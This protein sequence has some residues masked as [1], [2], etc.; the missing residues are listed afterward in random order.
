MDSVHIP[1]GPATPMRKTLPLLLLLVLPAA[2][3][4]QAPYLVKDINAT[5]AA[6]PASSNPY[7]FVRYGS[8]IVFSATGSQATGRELWSTDGTPG[9]TSLVA[10][11]NPG[12]SA[13]NPSH[14]AVVNGTLIF[15]ARDQRGDELWMSDGT[16][17]GTSLLADINPGAPSS[18]PRERIVYRGRMLFRASESVYGE[19]LWVT[20]G[21]PAGTRLLRDLV[22]GAGHSSPGSFVLFNDLVYFHATGGL[23]K[24]DGTEAGTVLVKPL[25]SANGLTLAG[26]R[27]FFTG[28]DAQ[29]GGEP[30]VSDGTEAGTRMIADIAP[31]SASSAGNGFLHGMTAFGDRVMFPANDSQHGTEMWISDGTAAGTRMLRD[32]APG[33]LHSA[34]LSSVAVL[35]GTA[36]FVAKPLIGRTELWKTDGTE[37]GTLLVRD[38]VPGILGGS[39]SSTPNLVAAGGKVFFGATNG[40]PAV[41]WVSDGTAQGTRP[42]KTMDPSLKVAELP[43]IFTSIDGVVYFSGAN[44]V[45]GYE[46]WKSDGTDAGTSMIANLA[47]DLAPSSE[48]DRLTAAADW[49]YFSAWNGLGDPSSEILT[50][51]LWRSD[52]TPEG[53]LEL[54]TSA[55]TWSAIGRS[56]FFLRSGSLW[57]TDGT[58]EGTG[59]ANEFVKRFP[60]TPALPFAVGDT[61]FAYAANQLWATTLTPGA[62][63]VP[64]GAGG[65]GFTDVAG[66]VLYFSLLSSPSRSTITSTDG[67]TAGT[68]IVS[69]DVMSSSADRAVMGG[70]LYFVTLTNGTKLWK[71]DGTADG[72][73][74]VKELPQGLGNMVAAGKNLFFTAG[75]QLWV[76]DGTEPGTRALAVSP[77][78][79]LAAVGNR[80]VFVDTTA[81][82]GAELWVS[83]GT[84]EGTG[85]VLDIRPGTFGSS[86][87]E[88]TSVAGLV[89]FV[90]LNDVYGS[91]LWVTDGTAAGTRLAADVEPGPG[92]SFPRQLVRA[93]ERL[94][95]VATTTATGRELWTLPLET[96]RLT[97]KDTRVAEGSG[98]TATARF[99]VTLTSAATQNVTVGYETSDGAAAAGSDYDATSGTLTFAAGETSKSITVPV[100]G[101][102]ASENDEAFFV[103][104]RNP[105][106]ATLERTSAFAVIEDDDRTA[107][108]SL[109]LDFSSFQS[110]TVKANASNSGPNTATNIKGALTATPPNP[111]VTFCNSCV[112]GQLVPG[113]MGN[114]VQSVSTT[115]PQRYFSMT[116]TARERDPNPSSNSVGWTANG[117][118]AMD[119][120]SLAPGSQANVWLYLSTPVTS[121]SLESS[122]P[123]VVSVPASVTIPADRKPV[124]FVARGLSA[125][126]ATIRAFTAAGTQSTLVID[127][128][129]PGTK[130]RWPG[131]I[132]VSA[133]N[134]FR[135]DQPAGITLDATA[136]APFNG[137]SATGLVTIAVD[138]R[139]V[140]RVTLTGSPRTWQVPSFYMPGVGA[141]SLTVDYAGDAN[142]LPVM[143]TSSILVQQGEATLRASADRAGTT[144][145]VRVTVTGSP[146]ATPTGTVTVSLPGVATP[147]GV[148]L[149]ST[150]PGVAT[151][152]VTV[153]SVPSGLTTLFLNYSGDA[154]YRSAQLDIRILEGRRRATGR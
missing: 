60:S 16:S 9:V 1:F 83:D 139:E 131:G 112:P 61:M 2:L 64:L 97:I 44:G 11:I 53:T 65:Y 36:L 87:S 3:L 18:N 30:W 120:L 17:A 70:C 46:P 58:P 117:G 125:G 153:S 66:R 110:A 93:G 88:L 27:L 25:F 149:T 134:T 105:A 133:S 5:T 89:Y 123:A 47:K 99:T 148:P 43:T 136:T 121:V 150:A 96:R 7:D 118:I 115:P 74:F 38:L 67:T 28:S 71:T 98:G 92:N 109:A 146:I 21:T 15:N 154:R 45:N 141:Q 32:I 37:A 107:D 138:G 33:P 57:M 52:G 8:R 111:S 34:S 132:T 151:A 103:T 62:G 19:E 128:V 6:S 63:A 26:S 78:G 85:L 143:Q 10:D 90:A 108:V 129:A 51:S 116:V 106:G 14:F 72:T 24:T 95:F 84:V 80:V 124:S 86:P 142:F 122:N 50:R 114:G 79:A 91:E 75:N 140:G 41:A 73:V 56:L 77:D 4:A 49:I 59:P 126:T 147:A 35:G 135:F 104:L 54:T 130:Q 144:A 119:A 40:G 55:D 76:T 29:L 42:L 13:S 113:A 145:T 31:G 48:P 69:T 39:G 12:V 94:Y 22:P 81:A 101:D 20:D 102:V 23:W 152:E 68:Y 137:Q 82:A 100:R 127:V